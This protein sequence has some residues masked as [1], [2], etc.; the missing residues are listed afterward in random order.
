MRAKVGNVSP[1]MADNRDFSSHFGTADN[2]A[3]RLFVSGRNYSLDKSVD[4]TIIALISTIS[5][6]VKNGDVVEAA[7]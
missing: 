1:D 5:A 4:F 6:L 2:G 7:A 3:A